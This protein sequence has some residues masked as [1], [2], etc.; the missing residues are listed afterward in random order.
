MAFTNQQ[1]RA[2]FHEFSSIA[3][4]LADKP[5][6]VQA[7]SDEDL[8]YTTKENIIYL[9]L[10]NEIYDTMTPQQGFIFLRGVFSHE[11]LHVLITDFT[12]YIPAIERYKGFAQNLYSNLLNILEDGSI[13]NFAPEYLSSDYTRSLEFVRAK[14]YQQS[15][16]IKKEDSPTQQFFTGILQFR[17]FG[18]LKGKIYDRKARRIFA[19]CV[20]LFGRC[21]EE[22]SQ[23]KR[24]EYA[25]RIFE[26]SRPLWEKQAKESDKAQEALE[27]MLDELM[28]KYCSSKNNGSGKGSNAS[29]PETGKNSA[30]NKHRR[31]TFRRI[32]AEEY[33]RM[34]EESGGE[35][36]ELP[37]DGDITVL[38]PDGPAKTKPPEGKSGAST[39][40]PSPSSESGE[41]RKDETNGSG[42]GD[43]ASK[44]DSGKASA[45][46][47]GKKDGSEESNSFKN[48]DSGTKSAGKKAD[49]EKADVSTSKEDNK[50]EEGGFGADK[51]K[52]GPSDETGNA[53][54]DNSDDEESGE[55]GSKAQSSDEADGASDSSDGTESNGREN[56]IEGDNEKAAEK[57]KG[58]G[59]D[60][61]SKEDGPE[62][63]DAPYHAS[64]ETSDVPN[65]IDHE[66]G[67]HWNTPEVTMTPE[68]Y[69]GSLKAMESEMRKSLTLT[70]EEVDAI[71]Q[72]N[73]RYEASIE[74]AERGTDGDETNLDLPVGGG[75]KDVCKKAKCQNVFVDFKASATSIQAYHQIVASMSGGIAS[76]TSQLG[77]I[78]RNRQEERM[79]KPSG[80]VSIKRLNGGRITS[81]VFTKRKLPDATE[82]AVALAIDISGSMSGAKIAVAQK[83]AIALAEVFGNLDIPLYV[84]G[85]S[86]DED[87]FDVSHF[88]YI[89]WSNKKPERLRLLGVKAR[90]NNFDG[91][92]IRYAT[93]LLRRKDADKKLLLVISDGNPAACAYRYISGIQDVQL[94]VGEANRVATTIG[95]L[96]GNL[97]PKY[98]R[99]MYGYNFVHCNRVQELFPQLARILKKYI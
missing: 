87:G 78:L 32:S 22:P 52:G 71:R 74:L 59:K 20:P 97:D 48:A 64:A 42:G 15:E 54:S 49:D 34:M 55:A 21:F 5:V 60:D 84:F 6:P 25:D 1:G 7:A 68:E 39:P 10:T 69:E 67:D 31:I 96:L 83:S 95:I 43:E 18:F 77:R 14:L 45:T 36:N 12:K 80:K 33:E 94:A 85:F 98:H 70:D 16:D 8:G 35:G 73:E 66:A 29:D 99:Q 76:L 2:F 88:H 30:I 61:P 37:P 50:K 86:A 63:N 62:N 79:Y 44:D 57:E 28:K 53:S 38:I 58:N 40:I 11:L 9:S 92:S 41:E 56:S 17:F 26:L 3:S 47:S 91:Y 81:R 13:E 72:V 24:I 27:E 82:M 19:K 90:A 65:N 4:C 51:G 89:N 46:P 23:E 93:E 75:F